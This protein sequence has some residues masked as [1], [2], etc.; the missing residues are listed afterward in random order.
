MWM[1]SCATCKALL[2]K[3]RLSEFVRCQCGW[4]WPGHT[5]ESQPRFRQQRAGILEEKA[6]RTV[7]RVIEFYIPNNFRKSPKWVSAEQRGKV[8]EFAPPVKKSA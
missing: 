2:K 3:L 5:D 7:A 4:E 8:I 1:R 6:G